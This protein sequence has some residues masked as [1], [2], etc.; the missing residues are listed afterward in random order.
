MKY[1][2]PDR[3]LSIQVDCVV[4]Q[5]RKRGCEGLLKTLSEMTYDQL[6]QSTSRA[7]KFQGPIQDPVKS[8][9]IV[10]KLKELPNEETRWCLA[11]TD[12]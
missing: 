11:T 12:M 5:P 6:I 9:E 2:Q 1:I 10:F 4:F 7:F 8:K 3:L